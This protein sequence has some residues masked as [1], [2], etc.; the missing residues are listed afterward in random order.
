MASG[1]TVIYK[2]CYGECL[3]FSGVLCWISILVA[4]LQPPPYDSHIWGPYE[5][6]DKIAI[7]VLRGC[8][9]QGGCSQLI[10]LVGAEPLLY[11]QP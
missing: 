11:S 2:A 5:G 9:R 4:W 8:Y 7:T 6:H 1:A 10:A 3:K